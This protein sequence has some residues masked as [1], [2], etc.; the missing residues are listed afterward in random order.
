MDLDFSFSVSIS[1]IIYHLCDINDVLFD[2]T[3]MKD[4]KLTSCELH[5]HH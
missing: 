1:N 5:S 3:K 4:R 2:V